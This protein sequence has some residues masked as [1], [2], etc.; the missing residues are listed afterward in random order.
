MS[1][2]ALRRSSTRPA[3]AALP[4]PFLSFRVPRRGLIFA[5]GTWFALFFA[6]KDYLSQRSFGFG[7]LWPKALWWKSMEWY[8]WALLSLA[9]FWICRTFYRPG[10]PW[11]PYALLQVVSGTIFSLIH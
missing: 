8:G 11:W 4:R 10:K 5:F 7:Y 1:S 2:A 6:S 3:R 9:I